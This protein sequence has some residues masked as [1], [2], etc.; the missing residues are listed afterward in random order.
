MTTIKIFVKIDNDLSD[1][2]PGYL[3][4]R[5]SE[6][7]KM[8]ELLEKTRAA[9]EAAFAE[10]RKVAHQI[11]GN[12]GSYGFHVLSELGGELETLVLQKDFNAAQTK[13]DEILNYLSH[14]ELQMPQA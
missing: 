5:R 8:K 2:A 3:E 6:A 7:P 13:I 10:L 4:R 9:D 14:V 11:A 12:A 1:L